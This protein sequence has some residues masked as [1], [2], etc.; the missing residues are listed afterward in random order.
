MKPLIGLVGRRK[1]GHQIAGTSEN[2]HGIDIDIYMSDYGRAVREA[3][4]LPILLPVDIDPSEYI[5]RLEGLVLTGG[6]DVGPERYGRV[7]ETDLFP[8]EAERDDLELA[9][10][11]HAIDGSLPVLGICRGLQIVNVHGGG[12]LHQDV[13]PHARYDVPPHAAVHPVEFTEGSV[14]GGLYGMRREVNSLHHQA[15]DDVA[16][17]YIVSARGDDG[18]VEGLEH[19][20]LPI[21]AVQWHPEMMTERATDP[22]FGWLVEAAI[23]LRA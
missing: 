11:G 23:S 13:P 14:L 12:T 3:G 15:V 22:I 16:P 9:L 6:T 19:E 1:K 10:M 5:D 17:G 18:G 20:S 8:P 7:A 4:G 21:V 2:L